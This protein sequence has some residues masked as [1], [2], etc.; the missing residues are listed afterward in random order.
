M[1][2]NMVRMPDSSSTPSDPDLAS[3][4][5][6]VRSSDDHPVSNAKIEVRNIASGTDVAFGFTGP[7]GDFQVNNLPRG[8]YEVVVT[9]GLAEAREQV[10]VD[11]SME[12][13][14]LRLPHTS[15]NTSS[16]QQQIVT[17]Q[18]LR[19][20]DKAQAAL[21]KAQLAAGKGKYDEARQ[22]IAKALSI[23]PKYSEAL[24]YRG[25]LEMQTGELDAASEDI[26]KAIE[27]DNSSVLAYVAMGSLYNTKKQFDDA[28]RELDRG[29]TLNPASWQA[30]YEI[31]KANLGKGDFSTALREVE[32]A[33]SL[34][35]R[36]FPLL[37]I[38][39]AQAL[40]GMKSYA[41]AVAEFQKFLD[42]NEDK[43]SRLA[44]QVRQTIESAKT[45][46]EAKK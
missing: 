21:K 46:T 17:V 4:S 35:N 6:S 5:A 36:E 19:V 43:D 25:L 8:S 3:I 18:Q 29:V 42:T 38:V 13:F 12:Q 27:F 20:P 24:A 22:Q 14:T 40:L 39:K 23:E 30:H 15:E 1:A 11:N 2:N 33:Q 31:S 37:H 32:K 9:S 45:F 16:P 10:R 41:D 7:S 26:Q 44:A 28:L 34:L